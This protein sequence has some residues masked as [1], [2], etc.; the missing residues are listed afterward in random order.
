MP[1]FSLAFH[2]LT[3]MTRNLP[4]LE[5]QS[6]GLLS[7]F[8]GVGEIYRDC[9]GVRTMDFRDRFRNQLGLLITM[10]SRNDRF[11]S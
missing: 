5:G 1:A 2:A 10:V 3:I 8:R 9:P 7:E 4:E 6:R 11:R